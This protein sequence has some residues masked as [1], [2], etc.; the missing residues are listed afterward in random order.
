MSVEESLRSIIKEEL[1]TLKREILVE[2][3]RSQLASASAM[4]LTTKEAAEI[5]RVTP[6][7]IR[8]WVHIG[9]L[10]D[11]RDPAPPLPRLAPHVHLARAG[12]RS[13]A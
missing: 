10:R 9:A 12:R 7:T 4:Y 5:A 2:L 6:A 11:R 8:E 3:R 13:P 1:A